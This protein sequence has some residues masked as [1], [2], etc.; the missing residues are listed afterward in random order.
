M[1][2]TTRTTMGTAI[3]AVSGDAAHGCATCLT[4]SFWPV[5]IDA[6]NLPTEDGRHAGVTLWGP[7]KYAI[8]DANGT[9]LEDCKYLYRKP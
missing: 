7:E 5:G 2:T 4:E 9:R 3:T 6:L 8:S 1:T